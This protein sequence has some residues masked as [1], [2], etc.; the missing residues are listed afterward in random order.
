MRSSWQWSISAEIYA[1][2][3]CRGI[4][5][6]FA[7]SFGVLYGAE[8]IP[9]EPAQVM[10]GREYDLI[11]PVSQ[12]I[13]S[14]ISICHTMKKWIAQFVCLV[15][16]TGLLAQ[17]SISGKI[18]NE[19]G[20]AL[21]GASI[22]ISPLEK[23]YVSADDGSFIASSLSDGL[24]DVQISYVG[25]EDHSQRVNVQGKD[26]NLAT[27]I[28]RTQTRVFDAVTISAEV[29]DDLDPIS[30]SYVN[31]EELQKL[32]TA[33]DVPF[34][35]RQ[36]SS[37]VVTSDAGTGIGYTGMR[38]RGSDATRVN[39]TI[40]GIP[41]NDSESQ[42][43]FWVNM[44]D[45]ATSTNNILV[46]RGLG[47]SSL[48]SGAFGATVGIDTRQVEAEP[49]VLLS[50]T[51]GSFDTRRHSLTLNSGM[52]N[53]HWNFQ[54]RLSRI[55][56]DG[57]VD[58]ATADLR[59]YYLSAN[60]IDDKNSL[61]LIHFAGK[62]RTY[63]SWFGTPQALANGDDQGI[64]DYCTRN[65][66]SEEDCQALR[67]QGRT[68]NFYTYEDEVDDYGQDHYQLHYDRVLTDELKLKLSLHYTQ[69][70]GFFEQERLDD[71]FSDYG[72]DPI[73][74]GGETFDTGDF[75]RRRWLDND[76]YGAVLRLNKS[77]NTD[78][79]EFGAAFHRYLGDHFGEVI[80]S[81]F[82]AAAPK[83]FPY[84]FSD[85]TKDDFNIYGK[86]E[87]KLTD[88]LKMNVD[89]QY[90]QVNYAGEGV[91]DDLRALDFSHD[92]SFFNPKLGLNYVLNEQ[93]AL[94]AYYG[95]GNREPD[96]NDFT[97][98]TGT[99]PRSERL[100]NVE[101]GYRLRK[102]DLQ[103]SAN[104]Y[105]MGYKDQLV[106][107]GALNDV[108][109]AIRTNVDE[110]YRLG[111]ELEAAYH[112][113]SKLLLRGNLSLNRTN[114]S[115]FDE[116]I[117]DFFNNEEIVIQHENTEIAYSPETVAFL[118]LSYRP[119]SDWELGLTA[120][121][122]GEQFLDNTSNP[123]RALESYLH[124]DFFAAYDFSIGRPKNGRINFQVFNVFNS[125]YSNNGYTFSYAFYETITENFVYPQADR[126]FMLSLDLRF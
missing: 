123:D 44:P 62:E 75:I 79:F 63:Q 73:T 18:I 107:T 38:I 56:S 71:D 76:Y 14:C 58:R 52:I 8:I 22:V 112:I 49:T 41:L 122:V 61:S 120:K 30:H 95:R 17:S 12:G 86:Y 100:D 98:S 48:G 13:P 4:S 1:L 110:S 124:S 60:Y 102:D 87:R 40:N 118:G 25:H 108:G 32:N 125:L 29:L 54:A 82:G 19:D 16:V 15:G 80:W 9:I 93:S 81:E 96:R 46:Q 74:V 115:S 72:I 109:G 101:L 103:V 83:D 45:L 33:K 89:L 10:L 36:T 39:V 77:G 66:L 126:H 6:S 84:Y 104:A 116:I 26:I 119:L 57:Y 106:L 50:N 3:K 28:L 47:G 42:G 59:S 35:L 67:S 70:A 111:L 20:E 2:N 91:N 105:Y 23:L 11:C 94:Y 64:D 5:L 27:I 114:I 43:V 78:G 97:E 21:V 7:T 117:F 37:T 88:K 31:K 90:R 69:G 99:D 65:F 51:I 24:Y 53:E 34:L 113:S 92:F 55:A 121:Y 85:A 68:Y